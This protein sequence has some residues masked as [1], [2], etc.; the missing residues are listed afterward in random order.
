MWKNRLIVILCIVGSSVLIGVRGGTGAYFLFYTSLLLPCFSLIYSLYVFSRFCIY[1][2]LEHR[3]VVK[4]E[5]IPYT[6][7]LAN[8]DK[9]PYFSV[10]VEFLKDYSTVEQVDMEKEYFLSP[11]EEI[12]SSTTLICHRRGEYQVG[13][14]H[15]RVMD[16]FSL[17]SI[18]YAVQTRI[19]MKVNPRIVVLADFVFDPMHR[20]EKSNRTQYG[21]SHQELDAE[22]RNYEDGDSMRLIHWKAL[23]ASGR[24][25][26]RK[27]KEEERDSICFAVD[28]YPAVPKMDSTERLTLEDKL[29]EALL[30][31]AD[32]YWRGRTRI[33][34]FYAS[35]SG[36][37]RSGMELS[38]REDIE[39][40]H[41]ICCDVRFDADMPLEEV[42]RSAASWMPLSSNLL[43]FTMALTMGLYEQLKLLKG[44]GIFSTLMYFRRAQME[45]DGFEELFSSEFSLV[46]I[47]FE[48]EPV[49]VLE[50]R[51]M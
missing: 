9:I 29:L 39:T 5:R 31:V 22:L 37:A 48:K 25:L 40:L 49:P 41:K 21:G 24:L 8:E 12:S 20:E 18:V 38:S 23:A 17:F 26:S 42:L 27:Y 28:F 10:S 43:L 2:K 50:G 33:Q 1:Q 13:I 32:Y 14:S 6:F 45:E 51:K 3:T 15:A 44:Y 47:P 11:G 46:V 4:E 34:L 35:V 36:E 19:E 30:S 16:Y 7:R